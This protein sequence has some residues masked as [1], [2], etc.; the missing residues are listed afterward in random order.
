MK[1]I[2]ILLALF[3]AVSTSATLLKV[4]NAS[5]LPVNQEGH[6]EVYKLD[7][8]LDIEGFTQFFVGSTIDIQLDYVHHI[9]MP[10]ENNTIPIYLKNNETLLFES[11]S[12]VDSASSNSEN[13]GTGTKITFAASTDFTVP[14]NEDL[15]LFLSLYVVFITGND[16]FIY[17]TPSAIS[18]VTP[19]VNH[20]GITVDG[21][22]A[23]D[24][25]GDGPYVSDISSP[26]VSLKTPEISTPVYTFDAQL[27]WVQN[28]A[29]LGS[30]TATPVVEVLAT[31]NPQCQESYTFITASYWIDFD[32]DLTLPESAKYAGAVAT[33]D[34]NPWNSVGINI[35]PTNVVNSQTTT[36]SDG[37]VETEIYLTIPGSSGVDS[38]YVFGAAAIPTSSL[39]LRQYTMTH[40][41]GMICASNDMSSSSTW[42]SAQ[43]LDIVNYENQGYATETFITTSTTTTWTKTTTSE[44]TVYPPTTELYNLKYVNVTVFLIETPEL[45]T[46][47]LTLTDKQW[48]GISE[49]TYSTLTLTNSGLNGT[50]TISTIYYVEIPES[51]TLLVTSTATVDTTSQ[52][53]Q[54]ST[55]DTTTQVT[56]TATVDITTQVTQTSTIDT[57]TQVTQTSTIDTTVLATHNATVEITTQVTQIAT[58]GITTQVTQT[59]T[60]NTTTQV[61][62]TATVDITTQVTQTSTI[63]TTTQVTQTSTIDTTTQVTQT[64]T[65][66]TTTQVTQTSTIDT[67]TQVTQTATVDT[68]TQVTQTSTID[69]TAKITQ[70]ATIDTTVLATHNAT[71]EIT[72]QVTQIATVGITTQVTQTSTINTTTQV[73]Q[74][75]TVDITTQVTQ[76]STID[77]TTQVTQTSTIDTTTQVT[78]TSTIDTTTQVTQTST[79]DTT[80]QVTQTATVDT[81]TQVTQTS[82][83]DMTAKITQ[84]ATIDTTVL[85]THNATVE[86]TT[87]VT[88]I[89]TVGITTQVTQTSTINTT[90]Q[91][92]QTA[93][94]DITT[95]VTQTSTIDTTTQITQTSTIDTTTQVTQ[96]ATIDTTS[97]VTQT[98]TVDIITQVTQT[99]TVD[100][101]TQVTQTSTIDMTAKITQT[102]T[103]DTTVL[104]THNA[105]V[106]ITTQAIQTATVEITTQV[107]Q[108]SIV[109]TTIQLLHTSPSIPI[110]TSTFVS[111]IDCTSSCTK[112]KNGSNNNTNAISLSKNSSSG[113]FTLLDT[114]LPFKS[115]SSYSVL[116]TTTIS[117]NAISGVSISEVNKFT[118]KFNDTQSIVKFDTINFNSSTPVF[119]TLPF[120]AT[121]NSNT[122]YFETL[123]PSN[124][125]LLAPTVQTRTH[126]KSIGIISRYSII[127]S[128]IEIGHTDSSSMASNIQHNYNG[129]T[130]FTSLT[131]GYAS[132]FQSSNSAEITKQSSQVVSSSLS[133]Y[134]N[135]NA[136]RKNV[137]VSIKILVIAFVTSMLT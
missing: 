28:Q 48:T 97:Q 56:Q 75:A 72:T 100:T 85:A 110:L 35:T 115:Q 126:T 46:S 62:Q 81:T 102:A 106:K 125:L 128:S 27:A 5:Y 1:F 23:T 95:Q 37:S 61:T 107:T 71:V 118:Y 13:F 52:V 11:V 17:G 67:T 123:S 89:A 119:V 86:I 38:Y 92:T 91:V 63:D 129:N 134:L 25:F 121:Q 79:I 83:I 87:Q 29:V 18:S 137:F 108:T 88:Q 57:T 73:T 104:A 74:T 20:L 21:T 90:T 31:F 43:I 33:G 12:G 94:V 76:T 113:N 55:I 59:S 127:A 112:T 117:K 44:T 114:M 3:Y 4:A 58:V 111:S 135:V 103:I 26:T 93:T 30:Q 9:S 39:Q 124:S 47:V 40:Y 116:L 130:T 109:N 96:T 99:A 77:T 60:I 42:E 45:V 120:I 105:T 136:A 51:T 131:G 98:A 6:S 7:L 36:L 78:Q 22:L 19:G 84:T 65:I 133:L 16:F 132:S 24:V 80:T 122:I 15:S 54:T 49:R 64:S 34:M 70:T 53:T 66:D 8:E 32:Y 50:S 10:F 68:T 101:T 69:M 2:Y 41:G 14:E 82:T